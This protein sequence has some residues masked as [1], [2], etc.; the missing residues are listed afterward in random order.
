MLLNKIAQ[1][2]DRADRGYWSRHISDNEFDYLINQSPNSTFSEPPVAYK[3]FVYKK[4]VQNIE[5]QVLCEKKPGKNS[6]FVHEVF[7]DENDWTKR[8][9]FYEFTW[10]RG[11]VCKIEN[12]CI[13]C[14]NNRASEEVLRKLFNQ[15]GNGRYCRKEPKLR[16]S[17]KPAQSNDV[18]WFTLKSDHI[19]IIIRKFFLGQNIALFPAHRMMK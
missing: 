7:H 17:K 6:P 11:C 12:L 10:G 2:K 18:W 15:N 9:L 4:S 16:K 19:A 3:S 1:K 8:E 13:Q 5:E 14:R